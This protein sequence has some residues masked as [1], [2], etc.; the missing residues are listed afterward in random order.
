MVAVTEFMDVTWSYITECK[1][2]ENFQG[3]CGLRTRTG[4]ED[5]DKDLRS[6][7]N[8]KD[9]SIGPWGSSITTTLFYDPFNSYW[10]SDC[11]W[12]LNT[13]CLYINYTLCIYLILFLFTW[14]YVGNYDSDGINFVLVLGGTNNFAPRY[15]P[16]KSTAVLGSTVVT[17]AQ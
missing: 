17:V 5:K 7:D 13:L 11:L 15:I 14:Q 1:V 6:K 9:L 10:T 3:L 2:L 4:S 16:W 8:D 12:S